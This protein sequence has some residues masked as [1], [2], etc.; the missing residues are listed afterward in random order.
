MKSLTS[1]ANAKHAVARLFSNS[2]S[3]CA[4]VFSWRVVDVAADIYSI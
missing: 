3:G 4:K 2:K 1:S